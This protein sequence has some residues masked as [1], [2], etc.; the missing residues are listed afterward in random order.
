MTTASFTAT[1]SNDRTAT[2]TEAESKAAKE[3]VADLAKDAHQQGEAIA[4]DA[5]RVAEL[6]PPIEAT[7]TDTDEFGDDDDDPSEVEPVFS[8]K[9]ACLPQP[10]DILWIRASCMEALK[11]FSS[12]LRVRVLKV[13]DLH[14]KPLKLAEYH[15]RWWTTP[16]DR[17]QILGEIVSEGKLKGSRYTFWIPG[18]HQAENPTLSF[19][20][21]P[22]EEGQIKQF[23]PE[24]DS[25]E[26]SRCT[27]IMAART[28]IQQGDA[29]HVRIMPAIPQEA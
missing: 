14:E 1:A 11:P 15:S 16:F 22:I 9:L 28:L 24:F 10:G 5:A 2:T 23:G 8:E 19:V 20:D 21:W 17:F 18:P 26:Y 25:C 13:R 29:H 3:A 4:A 27:L 6:A 12:A 7:P